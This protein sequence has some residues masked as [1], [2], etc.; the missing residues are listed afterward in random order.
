MTEPIRQGHSTELGRSPQGEPEAQLLK[1]AAVELAGELAEM[2]GVLFNLLTAP[3][4][5]KTFFHPGSL[6]Q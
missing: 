3:V 1:E 2:H 5:Y 6:A 4:S